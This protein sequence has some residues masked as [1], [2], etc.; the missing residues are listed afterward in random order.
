MESFFSLLFNFIENS[1][2]FFPSIN[3]K[4]KVTPK[5]MQNVKNILTIIWFVCVYDQYTLFFSFC[6]IS[7]RNICLIPNNPSKLPD[8]EI[9]KIKWRKNWWGKTRRRRRIKEGIEEESWESG[10]KKEIYIS[11]FFNLFHMYW[12]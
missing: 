5:I 6:L 1:E 4:M 8:W 9:S 3:F 11:F 2:T 12:N 10:R 7:K